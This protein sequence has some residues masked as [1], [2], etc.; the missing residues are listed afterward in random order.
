MN[1]LEQFKNSLNY[2]TYRHFR[3][4]ESIVYFLII[5]LI[6]SLIGVA[7]ILYSFK[8]IDTNIPT[9]QITNGELTIA[10]EEPYYIS[11]DPLIVVDTTNSTKLE[12]EGMLALKDRLI[13][14]QQSQSQ[15]I[16]FADFDNTT[17]TKENLDK[18]VIS[19]A[20]TA[21]IAYIVFSY[22]VYIV[23]V[24]LISLVAM[25]IAKSF[26]R[27]IQYSHLFTIC[28]YALTLVLIVD[29]VMTLT[30]LNVFLL[31]TVIYLLYLTLIIKEY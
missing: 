26:K 18:M 2:K 4:K 16:L 7:T 3:I 31:P 17:I 28:V 14:K 19:F 12:T 21:S 9:I 13:I 23:Y 29:L 25:L 15:E 8:D 24:L 1:F 20:F 11:N 5:V 27:R 30:G 6:F 22:I 10:A